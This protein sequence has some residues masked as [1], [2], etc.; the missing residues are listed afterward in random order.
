M[1]ASLSRFRKGECRSAGHDYAD[2]PATS[3]AA[4]SRS[5]HHIGIIKTSA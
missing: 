5:R 1:I 4:T 2:L 3:P